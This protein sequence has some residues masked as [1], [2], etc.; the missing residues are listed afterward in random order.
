LES[1]VPMDIKLE[2][3]ESIF[4]CNRILRKKKLKFQ[5]SRDLNPGF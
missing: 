2:N 4:L 3:K 1:N 5:V